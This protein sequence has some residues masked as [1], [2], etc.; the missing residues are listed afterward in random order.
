MTAQATLAQALADWALGV[1]ASDIPDA[2]MRDAE[3]RVLDTLGNCIAGSREP[4]GRA[5]LRAAGDLGAG[6]DA[7]I[8]PCGT[9]VPAGTAALVN[10]TFGHALDFDDTHIATL[11]HPSSP[12][13]AA[14][15][16]LAERHALDTRELLV[17]VVIGNEICCRLGMVAPLAFHRSGLHPTAVLAPVAT[18]LVAARIM[19]LDQAAAV[20][21]MGIAGSQA[22]GILESFSD[23]T[24]VKT[25]HAGWAAQSGVVAAT[26]AKAGFTGPATVLEGRFGLFASHVQRADETLDYDALTD[27]LGTHWEIRTCSLKPYACAHVIHPFVDL[28]LEL[29]REGVAADRIAEIRAPVQPGYIPVV[30]EPREVKIAPRTPTHARASLPYCVAAALL[31][32][33]LDLEAFSPSEIAAPDIR[34]LAARIVH[35]PD[36]EPPAP[37]RFR[38]VLHLR[39]EDGTRSE[40]RQ[41]FNRGSADHPLSQDEIAAKFR[42]NCASS[43]GAESCDAV[44]AACRSLDRAGPVADLIALCLS[45]RPT[46]VQR[47]QQQQ[48][49]PRPNTNP[50]RSQT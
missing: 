15:L 43:L 49:R 10:G 1:R 41:D 46:G 40:R 45:P 3:A 47:Q 25:F 28:A 34:A 23:G 32:G 36:P 5:M 39:M 13:V 35:D 9:R 6:A 2:L 48:G 20:H 26:M 42:A 17:C 37:G 18:A 27:R 50:K 11:V 30:C 22:S 21:A 19:G 12:V 24:W 31:R 7:A 14:A 4:L 33:K 8:L 16:A 38:G 29:H 44:I